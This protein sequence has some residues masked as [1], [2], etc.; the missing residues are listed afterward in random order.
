MVS[1]HTLPEGNTA[2]TNSSMGSVPIEVLH[3]ED[4]DYDLDLPPYHSGFPP[5]PVFPTHRGDLVL[6]VSNDEPVLDGEND[7]QRGREEPT[8][9]STLGT[10]P[11]LKKYYHHQVSTTKVHVC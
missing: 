11:P 5:F 3:P 10:P 1:V 4:K 7:K 9:L 6:N 2:S 8:P